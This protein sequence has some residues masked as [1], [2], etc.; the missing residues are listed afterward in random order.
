MNTYD[1]LIYNIKVSLSSNNVEFKN[2]VQATLQNYNFDESQ[3]HKFKID[4]NIDFNKKSQINKSKLRIGNGVFIDEEHKKIAIK[5]R[6]F[7][8]EFT[9]VNDKNLSIRGEVE[10]PFKSKVKHLIKNVTIKHYSYKEML[11]H[12]LYR[13][14]ILM[15]VFWVL[16]HK[17]DKYLMHASAV[18]DG[19]Q[20]MVF[21]GNDG[22]GKTTVALK[23]LQKE[24]VT[25]FGDNFLLYDANQINAFVDTLRVNKND[26]NAI[27]A[28]ES[29]SRFKKVYEGKARMHYN[30]NKDFIS[31][32]ASPTH[33][34]VL[35]QSDKN[36]KTSITSDQFINYTFAINDYVK[37]FD[38]YSF[39][40]NLIFLYNIPFNVVKKETESL[41]KLV[42]NKSCA[43]LGLNNKSSTAELLLEF[44]Q[45]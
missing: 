31:D 11:F 6:L 17:F 38:K 4:V 5:H 20:T 37:E 26:R 3:D 43:V 24:G 36:S 2:F 30:F 22:V 32:S 45:K 16:R 29:S 40:S 15:P 23:L 27:K 1:F 12:Q 8:G 25:F 14:L 35:K 41:L 9:Y 39:A 28:Y 42:S 21:L 44:I 13:E 18:S 33:F 7:L 19:K 10:E 34:Y